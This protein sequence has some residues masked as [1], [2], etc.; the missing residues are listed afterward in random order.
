MFSQKIVNN[1]L[2]NK[3]KKDCKS[4]NYRKRSQSE[5]IRDNREELDNIIQNVAP[6]APKND[7]ERRMWVENDEGLYNAWRFDRDL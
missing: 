4:K 2:G 7:E 3:P 5:W 6:G 1:I